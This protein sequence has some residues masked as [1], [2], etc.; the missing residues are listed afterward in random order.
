MKGGSESDEE[1]VSTKGN[2][3]RARVSF[4][5]NHSKAYSD[6][7]KALKAIDPSPTKLRRSTRGAKK[8]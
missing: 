2:K 8:S 7:V 5:K 6:S 4:G 3:K 1:D